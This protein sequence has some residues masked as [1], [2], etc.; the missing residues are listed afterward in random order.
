VGLLFD[1]LKVLLAIDIVLERVE[2]LSSQRFATGLAEKAL[3]VEAQFFLADRQALARQDEV[4]ATLTANPEQHFV[5]G[6]AIL[7]AVTHKAGL[8]DQ[9]RL[10]LG[11]D[12]ALWMPHLIERIDGR[13]GTRYEFVART[14]LGLPRR[15][16][17]V[18]PTIKLLIDW[19]HVKV[20]IDQRHLAHTAHQARTVVVTIVDR[21]YLAAQLLATPK[22]YKTVDMEPFVGY[23]DHLTDT[24]RLATQTTLFVRT[25]DRVFDGVHHCCRFRSTLRKCKPRG[26]RG[27]WSRCWSWSW[28]WHI[29]LVLWDLREWRML[30]F[31]PSLAWTHRSIICLF[32]G[33][34]R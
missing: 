2:D 17:R 4:F 8:S 13:I 29:L 19:A 34:G 23:F 28:S 14:T 22:A 31:W 6:L 18:Q 20:L 10:A 1:E 16:P 33:R 27:R 30:D 12:K 21:H 9:R 3:R 15:R 11:T 32:W 25:I 26:E 24:Q 5:A 7:V